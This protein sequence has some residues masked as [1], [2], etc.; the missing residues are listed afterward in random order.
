MPLLRAL[1]G[2]APMQIVS[3]LA[4]S[5]SDLAVLATRLTASVTN[6]PRPSLT[7]ITGVAIDRLEHFGVDVANDA[8]LLTALT[9]THSLTAIDVFVALGE[10]TLALGVFGAIPPGLRTL[11]V[12]CAEGVSLTVLA[13]MLR[14][15]AWQS[16]LACVAVLSAAACRAW[17]DAG[18]DV[19]I[20]SRGSVRVEKRLEA[21]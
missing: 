16:T 14:S 4:Q 8:R 15:P 20:S 19:A 6:H 3:Q 10:E 18:C 11:R 12:D 13:S 1:V 2:V 7:A 9:Q 5:A 17:A 21:Q